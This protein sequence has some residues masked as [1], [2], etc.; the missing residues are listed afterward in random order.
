M[1]LNNSPFSS[2]DNTQAVQRTL[3]SGNKK[4]GY[5]IFSVRY[6]HQ[7]AVLGKEIMSISLSLK[8]DRID[9]FQSINPPTIHRCG[10]SHE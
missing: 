9:N 8:S 6:S 2:L 1:N 3:E 5:H 10:Y 7:T 4:V